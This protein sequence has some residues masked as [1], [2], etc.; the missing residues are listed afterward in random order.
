MASQA[1]RTEAVAKLSRTTARIGYPDRWRDYSGLEIR[2]DDL[3]GN[4]QRARRF[5]S[6]YRMTRVSAAVAGECSPR[7]RRP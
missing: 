1:T 2:A 3:A 4:V 5:D 6:D 7:H